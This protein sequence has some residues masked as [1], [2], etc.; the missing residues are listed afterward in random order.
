MHHQ[1]EL[2]LQLPM[3]QQDASTKRGGAATLQTNHD[4]FNLTG[5]SR[6]KSFPIASAVLRKLKL[7]GSFVILLKAPVL[8]A[9]QIS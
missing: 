7:G 5:G 8:H 4:P 9:N 1:V 2:S 6:Q 3:L